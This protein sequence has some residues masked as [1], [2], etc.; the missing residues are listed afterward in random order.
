MGSLIVESKEEGE[1]SEEEGT[2]EHRGLWDRVDLHLGAMKQL[3]QE[4]EIER[5]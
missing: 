5:Q 4:R 1:G 2:P 3:T